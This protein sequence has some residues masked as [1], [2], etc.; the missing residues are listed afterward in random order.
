VIGMA[1]RGTNATV[2]VGEGRRLALSNLTKPLF[3]DGTT[4]AQLIEYYAT[5]APVILK[6]LAGRPVT[7]KRY[8]D[9][10]A[11]KAFFEKRCPKHRPDWVRTVT[12]QSDSKTIDYCLIED[13]GTLVIDA[14]SM[15]S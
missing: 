5:I 1:G 15:F 14:G 2:D 6:H 9:G 8:P 4:K 3:P 12:V 11:G 10:T 7:F 13:V